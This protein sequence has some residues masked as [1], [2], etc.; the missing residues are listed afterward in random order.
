M[1]YRELR[2]RA[3][4]IIGPTLS[5]CLAVYFCYH[6]IAGKHGTMA[7]REINNEVS[8]AKAKLASLKAEQQKLEHHVKFLRPTSLCTDLLDE[9][10]RKI[11]GYTQSNEIVILHHQE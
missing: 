1:I 2:R 7:W 6:M 5:S 8:L 4:R 11:L 3:R 9:Q 10:S